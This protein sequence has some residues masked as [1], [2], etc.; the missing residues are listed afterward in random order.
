MTI[1]CWNSF[2][3]DI[4]GKKMLCQCSFL[5]VLNCHFRQF[6]CQEHLRNI[7]KT[8]N[9]L[10]EMGLLRYDWTFQKVFS[11]AS[12]IICSFF[13]DEL[14][15]GAFK[16]DLF[17]LVYGRNVPCII[18]FE[19]WKLQSQKW[20]CMQLQYR[21]FIRNQKEIERSILGRDNA[22]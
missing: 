9:I 21:Y 2:I 4:K 8:S 16:E 10:N 20:N 3:V 5:N 14:K 13:Y 6:L 1:F 17:H 19:A 15:L 7:V 11:W 12:A 22:I 18:I